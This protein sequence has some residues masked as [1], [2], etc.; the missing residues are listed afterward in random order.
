MSKR[1]KEPPAIACVM[2][3]K[4]C[5]PFNAEIIPSIFV[6]V[7]L[8]KKSRRSHYGYHINF[9]KDYLS[10][11]YKVTKGELRVLRRRI[12]AVLKWKGW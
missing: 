2:Y 11:G 4:E 10:I 8:E 12:D 3:M 1:H 7:D 6:R 5:M 9:K